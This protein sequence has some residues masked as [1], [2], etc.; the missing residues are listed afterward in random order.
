MDTF[1]FLRLGD[2]IGT[3]QTGARTIEIEIPL[4]GTIQTLGLCEICQKRLPNH[5]EGRYVL[6]DLYDAEEIRM[7]PIVEG[8]EMIIRCYRISM[9]MSEDGQ[10]INL[11]IQGLL[12]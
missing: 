10:R 1:S 7:I 2:L 9:T 12:E 8:A 4:E 3:K 6:A 11:V 5:Y